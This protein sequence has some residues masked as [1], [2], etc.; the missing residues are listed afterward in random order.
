MMPSI[1]DKIATLGPEMILGLGACLCLGLGLAPNIAVRRSCALVAWLTLLL[2]FFFI[3]DESSVLFAAAGMTAYIKRAIVGLGLLLLMAVLTL[4]SQWTGTLDEEHL[5]HRFDPAL[6]FRGEF[7]AFFLLSLAGTMLTA[8][9]SDLVWLFLSLELASLPTY[10]MI[11]ISRQRVEAYEAAVKY[12]FLGAFAVA[13]FLFGFTLI[14]GAS[15]ATDFAAI[16]R[17]IL[18]AGQPS[19]L[20]IVGLALA[21]LGISFKIA[22]FPMHFYAPDVYQGAA[23]PIAAFLAFVPKTAGF[24]ALMLLL[25]IPETLPPALLGLIAVQA[26]LTMTVG[27]VLGLLQTSVKR[28]LAYSSIAHSGYMLLGLLAPPMLIPVAGPGSALGNG[29]AGILFYLVAYGLA[30]VAAFAVIALLERNGEEA[31]HFDDMAGLAYRHPVL[32]TILLLSV[33]SLMG[34][35]PLVGFAGKVYLFGSVFSRANVYPWFV[36]LVVIAVINSAVSG[37]YYL[38]LAGVCFFESPKDRLELVTSP[39]R[40]LAAC[41]AAVLVTALGIVAN[42][43]VSASRSAFMP[44]QPS[45]TAAIPPARSA[46]PASVP[47][48]PT[49][50]TP[51]STSPTF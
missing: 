12:F 23:A 49:T 13:L 20:M 27:N 32:A 6:A 43:L 41:A 48:W 16:R 37:V 33:F 42:P 30:T 44:P 38:R 50:T 39:T 21:V 3:K 35:P 45:S 1:F 19:A 47:T 14:Y 5:H 29:Y 28:M 15:G 51:Q 9:A 11:A 18:F 25:N 17:S 26:V 40:W 46:A 24:V 10:V 36:W 22:A 4:P 34:L 31:D 2:A 8:G 7:F